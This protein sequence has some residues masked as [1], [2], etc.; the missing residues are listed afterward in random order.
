MIGKKTVELM[1]DFHLKVTC[2]SSMPED[3]SDQMNYKMIMLKRLRI[4]STSH[5]KFQTR[6]II[7]WF[8]INDRS[9]VFIVGMIY[10]QYT[11]TIVKGSTRSEILD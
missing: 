6:I 3:G 4:S 2:L 1:W 8:G 10:D 11:S 9:N 5:C 7:L